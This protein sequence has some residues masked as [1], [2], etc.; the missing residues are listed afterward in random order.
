VAIEETMAANLVTVGSKTIN[1]DRVAFVQ[2]D[3]PSPGSA[4]PASTRGLHVFWEGGELA[5]T[6]TEADALRFWLKNSA[7]HPM[8]ALA[9]EPSITPELQLRNTA[10]Y[11]LGLL[12]DLGRTYHLSE[13]QA[14]AKQLVDLIELELDSQ[15]QPEQQDE[16]FA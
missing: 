11:L 3:N 4:V 6:G 2:D 8:S 1:M 5:L 13:A 10:A 7:T 16:F 12:E 14:V 9:E 15:G